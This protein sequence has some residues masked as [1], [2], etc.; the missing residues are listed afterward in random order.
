[1][2][3]S[4]CASTT[5]SISTL[6]T[7]RR[8]TQRAHGSSSR[9]RYDLLLANKFIYNHYLFIIMFACYSLLAAATR[10]AVRGDLLL[11]ACH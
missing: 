11:A 10:C 5:L 7:T 1:M 2:R 8:G 3:C 4:G 9:L 6:I